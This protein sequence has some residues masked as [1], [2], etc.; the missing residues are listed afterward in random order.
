MFLPNI[1]ECLGS[2]KRHVHALFFPSSLSSSSIKIK[3]K[4][5]GPSCS[6]NTITEPID[7]TCMA[8]LQQKRECLVVRSVNA[9]QTMS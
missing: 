9:A 1:P 6:Q 3:M 5:L 4:P 7:D 8:V 2:W